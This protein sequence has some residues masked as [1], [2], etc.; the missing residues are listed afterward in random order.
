[1]KQFDHERLDV[2]QVSIEFIAIAEEIAKNFPKGRAYI[3]DQLR[4]A[5]LSVVLNIA[6]GAG[7]FSKNEKIRFY[8]I[9]RRSATECAAILDVCKTL[10]VIENEMLTTARYQ[11]VRVIS[12]L[13][14][15]TK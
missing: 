7:E 12:M 15:M 3:A 2:Y 1:M 4:R 11:L 10:K 9:A 8:R 6:E 13:V 14:K 5:A